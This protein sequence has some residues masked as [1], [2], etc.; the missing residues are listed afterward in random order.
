MYTLIR[1]IKN[2]KRKISSI[3]AFTS[4]KENGG[5]GVRPTREA[6]IAMLGKHVWTVIKDPMKHWAQFIN[7]KYLH[8]NSI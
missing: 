5:L 6:D 4:A 8:N 1:P 7:A 3:K 2:L